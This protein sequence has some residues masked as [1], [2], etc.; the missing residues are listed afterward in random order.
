[1]KK[2]T[3]A[4]LILIISVA[5]LSTCYADWLDSLQSALQKGETTLDLSKQNIND[6]DVKIIAEALAS[7]ECKL[8]ELNL[9]YNNISD[10]GVKFIAKSFSSS[11]RKLSELNILFFNGNNISPGGVELFREIA[12]LDNAQERL[13]KDNFQ[14]QVDANQGMLILKNRRLYPGE[15]QDICALKSFKKLALINC[16]FVYIAFDCPI[17]YDGQPFAFD[18]NELS[19]ADAV[20]LFENAALETLILD[21]CKISHIE[22]DPTKCKL[23]HLRIS[24]GRLDAETMTRIGKIATLERLELQA[25]DLNHNKLTA[26]IFALYESRHPIKLCNLDLSLNNLGEC[27]NLGQL[28]E[29]ESLRSLYLDDCCIKTLPRFTPENSRIKHL[30]IGKNPPIDD[31]SIMMIASIPGLTRLEIYGCYMTQEAMQALLNMPNLDLLNINGLNIMHSPW[32]QLQYMEI[33]KA[34]VQAPLSMYHYYQTKVENLIQPDIYMNAPQNSKIKRLWVAGNSMDEDSF[35]VIIQLP[36]LTRLNIRCCNADQK[37]LAHVFGIKNL[38][39]L[40]ITHQ[41]LQKNWTLKKGGKNLKE[42]NF[43]LLP[44]APLFDDNPNYI[45]ENLFWLPNLESV[46]G[47]PCQQNQAIVIES[48]DLYQQQRAEIYDKIKTIEQERRAQPVQN[49]EKSQQVEIADALLKDITKKTLNMFE[50]G[51]Q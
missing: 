51:S 40:E 49:K 34:W 19:E 50:S 48:A 4:C 33:T 26:F 7:P 11:N 1:M 10:E 44:Q 17:K 24:N 27:T 32:Q 3:H 41:E 18:K 38:E 39:Y 36:Q 47:K 23:K 35:K 2:I 22:F 20:C 15:I 16:G 9:E 45:Q 46:N 21:D 13:N 31:Q 8:T 5:S 14:S 12:L 37:C 25:C 29:L 43:G 42:L 6:A 28:F 30:H